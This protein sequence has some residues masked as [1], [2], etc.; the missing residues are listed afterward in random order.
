MLRPFLVARQISRQLA[1]ALYIVF[2][3]AFVGMAGPRALIFLPANETSG[4]CRYL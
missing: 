1:A 4:P 2:L 3:L